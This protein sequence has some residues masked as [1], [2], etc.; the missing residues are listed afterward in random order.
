MKVAPPTDAA[1][2]VMLDRTG[3]GVDAVMVKASALEVPPLAPGVATLI[4]ADPALAISAA[5]TLACSWLLLT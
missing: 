1:V 5:A 4:W 2:G 3:A